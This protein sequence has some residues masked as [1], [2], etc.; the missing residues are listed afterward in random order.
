MFEVTGNLFSVFRGGLIF[1]T[2]SWGQPRTA[3]YAG[4]TSFTPLKKS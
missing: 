3:G 4:W 2:L 1:V